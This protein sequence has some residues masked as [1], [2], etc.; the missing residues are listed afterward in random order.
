[1]KKL[2]PAGGFIKYTIFLHFI[3]FSRFSAPADL[4]AYTNPLKGDIG[5][6]DPVMIKQGGTY[7][8]FY[9]GDYIPIKTST[10]RINWKESGKVFKTCPAWFKTYVPENDG[11]NCWAPD[12]YF[13]NDK[14]WLYYAVSTFGKR[15]SAIGLA[16]IPTLDRTSPEY[17]WTDEGMVINSTNGN[18]YNCIDAN[19]FVDIDGRV[20]LDFGSWN[21]GIKMVELNAQTGK[22]L[23]TKPTV[24]SIAA[25]KS[26]G[27]GIEAPFI[28]K[29]GDYYYQFVS[30][31]VC[32]KGVE[33]T[34]NI[35]VGRASKVTGPYGD[36]DKV[37]MNSG[38]GTL[39]DDG[40][41][42]W[43]GPGHNGVFVENDTVFL[44]NHA[45]DAQANGASKLMIR[46]LY[47][48]RDGW[49]TLDSSKGD[50]TGTAGGREPAAGNFTAAIR[51]V[52]VT[53]GAG[54]RCGPRAGNDA[55]YTIT[56]RCVGREA[57]RGAAP[58]IYLVRLVET[59]HP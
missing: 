38:G 30:W 7:Y 20:W 21:S 4:K 54:S 29:R 57:P 6:H 42:R 15:V 25:R 8:I 41:E 13:R 58:G 16:T 49:P 9:T 33:S 12:I 3:I 44:V 48:D 45:Y 17:K 56:G 5:V 59:Q 37:A 40:D 47:W 10:D 28:I 27:T 53:G 24:F 43:I 52:M 19:L 18:N 50:V 34:Y 31:D 35:R 23:S 39:I 1:M 55:F 32:C 36:K 22:L 46:P 11:K 2:V 51:P 26:T 14:Y